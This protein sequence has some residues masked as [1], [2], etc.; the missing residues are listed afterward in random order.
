MPTIIA[1]IRVESLIGLLD[2]SLLSEFGV[3]VVADASPLCGVGVGDVCEARLYHEDAKKRESEVSPRV[4]LSACCCR[5]KESRVA[6]DSS[7]ILTL[8][9]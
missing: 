6:D 9:T 3:C 2:E 5:H 7:S 8:L 4:C 1:F